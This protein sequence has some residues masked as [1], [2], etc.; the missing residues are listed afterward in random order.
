MKILF[1]ARWVKPRSPDGITRYSRELIKE[2]AKLK[3]LDLWLLIS[4]KNQLVGLPKL[5][6]IK[7][8]SPTSIKEFTQAKKINKYGFNG[9]YSPHFIFG[10]MGKNFK[11]ILTVLD[12]I[13]FRQ[14]N[15]NSKLLWKLF[16]KSPQFLKKIL[17]STDGVVTISN[18]VKKE[19]LKFSIKPITVVYSAPPEVKANKSNQVKKQL[20][21]IGRYEPYKNVE[22][23][24]KAINQLKFYKLLL[25]GNIESERKN[26]LLLLAKDKNQIEFF[27]VITDQRYFR[28]LADSFA[29]VNASKDEGFGLPLVEAMKVGCPVIC[30]NIATFREV[31]DSAALFFGPTD[32]NKL[33]ENIHKLEKGD[34]RNKLISLGKK[35]VTKFSWQ[36]SAD[37][38]KSFLLDISQND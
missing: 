29:L 37:K 38:L 33:V 10:S 17:K 23:L 21:Y 1:D 7:T 3:K 34:F 14:K 2:L 31:A 28:E 5:P 19:V 30:S 20:I 35:R 9:V 22:T 13:P 6:I 4:N 32:F 26:E 36:K 18:T 15:P 27:G 8:N 24:I 25:V 11:L 12:L 16:Y